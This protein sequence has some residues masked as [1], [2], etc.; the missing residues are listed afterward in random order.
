MDTRSPLIAR[1]PRL[2][3][4]QRPAARLWPGARGVQGQ[5]VRHHYSCDQL[6]HREGV[7]ADQGDQGLPRC[8]R[9]RA[10]RE[11]LAAKRAGRQGRHGVGV[12]E[13]D[14]RSQRG[15]ALHERP[16]AG[17]AGA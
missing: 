5:H 4:V 14:V 2:S 9:R 11:L 3:Q 10:A 16:W 7:Q 8:G 12:H 6:C 17:V 13:Y 15:D 1:G